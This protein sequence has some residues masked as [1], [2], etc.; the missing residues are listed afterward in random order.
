MIFNRK[1]AADLTAASAILSKDPEKLQQDS[2]I[3]VNKLKDILHKFEVSLNGNIG[4]LKLNPDVLKMDHSYDPQNS[5]LEQLLNWITADI[6]LIIKGM[7]IA[8]ETGAL[9]RYTK[10]D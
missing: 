3:H 2:D 5:E 9:S 8:V 6:Q 7:E 4:Q 10:L 1:V